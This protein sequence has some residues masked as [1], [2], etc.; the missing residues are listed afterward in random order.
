M[1]P[2]VINVDNPGFFYSLC[3]ITAFLTAFILLTIEGVRRKFSM[4]SWWL[5]MATTFLF[6]MI[7]SQL[8]KW[9]ALDWLQA[10][11]YQRLSYWPGRS[12][13]GGILFFVPA[14]LLAKRILNFRHNV[15]DTFAFMFPA[16][17]AIQ[18]VGCLLAGCCHGIPAT[19]PWSIQ[20][21]K[22]APAF[23]HQFEHGI[24]AADAEL[25]LPVHP[26]QLY[27]LIGCL[28][29]L[30]ILSMVRK[31]VKATGNLLAISLFLYGFFRLFLEEVKAQAIEPV[32]YL[33]AVQIAILV[34][35][36]ALTFFIYRRERNATVSTK[37]IACTE[38]PKQL[39][40]YSIGL[41]MLFLFVS[42]WMSLFEIISFNLVLF[43]ILSYCSWRTYHAFTIPAFR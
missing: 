21:N 10:L 5:V 27:D 40:T 14:L 18:R 12:V 30:V 22:S 25:P 32:Y 1:D 20:Y 16:G 24:I 4:L 34:I 43:P 7:G 31:K 29:I 37:E 41:L 19:L 11:E 8:I 26:A 36:P 3:Y 35:L 39:Y 23:Q 13:L 15:V 42:R 28:A 17:L 38:S 33:N 6:F 9:N 2:I